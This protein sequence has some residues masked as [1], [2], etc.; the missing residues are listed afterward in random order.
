M[1]FG[2]VGLS[3]E[4]R[5]LFFVGAW[6]GANH[7]RIEEFPSCAGLPY[8]SLCPHS[9]AG[10][11]QDHNAQPKVDTRLEREPPF[12]NTLTKSFPRSGH[13]ALVTTPSQKLTHVSSESPDFETHLP[14]SVPRSSH[15][16]L[17]QETV[18]M[19]MFRRPPPTLPS[20]VC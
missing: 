7:T 20:L 6:G 14:R 2:H 17:V 8:A 13:N 4:L 1:I 11:L 9:S 3:W 18:L 16:A 19:V 5:C 12:R 15:S 10:S